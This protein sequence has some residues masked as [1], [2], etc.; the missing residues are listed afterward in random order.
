MSLRDAVPATLADAFT[1]TLDGWRER[2]ATAR[3][4]HAEHDRIWR[5]LSSYTDREL[6]DLGI[7]HADIE[8]LARE[9][10][11]RAAGRR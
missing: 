3:T 11:D 5:E 6:A 8:G 7:S 4:W 2:L 10:A 9:H 1:H